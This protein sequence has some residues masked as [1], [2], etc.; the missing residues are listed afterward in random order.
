MNICEFLAILRD[1]GA[2]LN[3]QDNLGL[4]SLFIELKNRIPRTEV[5][6]FLVE[7]NINTR[8][9]DA[10]GRTA[11]NI[12][13]QN[14]D[15]DDTNKREIVK[16]LL[17]SEYANV[18]T[19][20][21]TEKSAFHIAI[22][23]VKRNSELFKQI[24]NHKSCEFPLHDCIKEQVPE[25]LKISA[26]ELLLLKNSKALHQHALNRERETLLITAAKVC[27]E[28]VSLFEFLMN[29]DIDVNARDVFQ[30]TAL[31]YLIESSNEFEFKNRKTT[32]KCVLARKPA[33]HDEESQEKTP[34]SR[35]MLFMMTQSNLWQEDHLNAP[36][37]TKDQ[38]ITNEKEYLKQPKDVFVDAEIVQYILEIALVDLKNFVEEKGRTYLHYCASTR[39]GG[40]QMVA[41]CKRLVELGVDV[42]KKDKD[43]HTCVDMALKYTKK[44][45]YNTLVY[46][47]SSINLQDFDVDNSLQYLADGGNLYC[48][49]V[50][51][52]VENVFVHRKPTKNIL[53]YLASIG[54]DPNNLSKRERK[55]LFNHLQ[56]YFSV[57]E[58]N[59][60]KNI[61]L[62][63]AI[64]ETSSVS[65]ALNFLRISAHNIT[66]ADGQGNTALHLIL[67]SDREDSDVC[68]IVKKVLKYKVDVNARNN[69]RKTPLMVAVECEKDRSCSIAYILE[70][71]PDV[72]LHLKDRLGLTILHYCIKSPKD[73]FTAYSILS[74]FLDSRLPV[75]VNSYSE[76]KLTA[77]N[78]AAKTVSYSRVLCILRLLNSK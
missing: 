1:Y 15:F 5:I 52:F 72:N 73:D 29:Q 42:N 56:R 40:E 38:V 55:E 41:I 4:N 19:R 3:K 13:L 74:L 31:D 8:I 32:I 28:M 22:L 14:P 25:D 76:E 70:M 68:A 63:I 75:Q 62:H 50:D 67:G 64:K 44:E 9:V 21:K 37:K 16:S 33:V 59:D 66:K 48:E 6:T 27:P 46:L 26:L 43:G 65:C 49:I 77:L 20:D 36:F 47:L 24:A 60:E 71:K 57:D 61:P 58:E 23:Y 11:L 34:L 10:N 2:D 53:H 51:Y 39:F 18:L 54:Y 69:F 17:C 78:M 35:V 7:A 45:N 30:K 12:A